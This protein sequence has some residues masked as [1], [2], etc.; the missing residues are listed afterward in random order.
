MNVHVG[1]TASGAVRTDVS[2]LSGANPAPLA[3]WART[4]VGGEG[5]GFAIECTVRGNAWRFTC[6]HC[7]T[8]HLH[9]NGPGHRVAHCIVPRS[10]FAK[11]G[12]WIIRRQ[13]RRA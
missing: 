13:R 11:T 2:A 6:P 10:P 7:R 4:T 12:Y 3:L 8:V 9:G 5:A 1:G